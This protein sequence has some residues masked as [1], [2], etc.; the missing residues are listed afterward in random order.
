MTHL[1]RESFPEQSMLCDAIRRSV[2]T[3]DKDCSKNQSRYGCVCVCVCVCMC[4]C[5]CVAN[6]DKS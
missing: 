2:G 5:V 4:V 6:H 3:H 1:I